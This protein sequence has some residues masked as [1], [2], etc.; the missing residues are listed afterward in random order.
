MLGGTKADYGNAIAKD[1]LYNI[2]VVGHT[3]S[4]D[5][6]LYRPLDWNMRGVTDAFVAKFSSSG[7]LLMSTLLGGSSYEFGN[8]IAID[9]ADNVWGTGETASAD[10]PTKSPF[11]VTQGEPTCSSPSWAP[12]A[13]RTSPS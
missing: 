9:S 8:G 6:S 11:P 2:Y 12:R 1:S 3:Y 5:F 4:S 7:K 13:G 10:F